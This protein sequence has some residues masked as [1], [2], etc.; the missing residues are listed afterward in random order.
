LETEGHPTLNLTFLLLFGIVATLL[1]LLAWALRDP[2]K[3]PESGAIANAFE[4]SDR[5]HV[6][7][8]PQIRQALDT[9]DYEF[10]EGKGAPVLQRRVRR[11][12]R[13][14]AL[15]YLS[16][17]RQDFQ[18]LLRMARII[19]VL[20]PEIVVVQEFERLRLTVKFLWRYEM[21]RMKLRVGFLSLP[22]LDAL[23]N[24]ISGLSVRLEKAIKELGERAALAAELASPPDR[25]GI[26][27]V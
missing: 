9:A 15:E 10:L 18:G 6:N 20:S 7:F 1:L 4:R 17:L 12:R 8:L 11:E 27:L 14:V 16:S 26:G 21:I 2:G 24:L 3:L 22:Q 13:D 23:G 19:A 25:R 5:L